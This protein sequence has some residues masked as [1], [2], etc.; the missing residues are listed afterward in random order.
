MEK[1]RYER[2]LIQKMN[3]GLM[4]KFGTRSENEPVTHIEGVQVKSL[5]HRYGSPLFVLSERQMRR[6]I[7]NA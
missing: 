1:E 4:N 3:T 7:Q 6:N 5:L 2:P